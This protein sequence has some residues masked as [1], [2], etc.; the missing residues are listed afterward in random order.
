M[1]IGLTGGIGCGK[2]TALNIFAEMGWHTMSTDAIAH[3][4]ITKDA[5]VGAELMR[6][7]GTKEK[8]M[9]AKEVF[10]NVEKKQDLEEILHPRIRQ[11]WLSKIENNPEDN[12]VIEI[13]LLIEKSL[14][15]YFDLVVCVASS[16]ENQLERL[17]LRGITEDDAKARI[18]NQAPLSLK[19]QNSDR[20]LSNNGTIL[21][22]EE[23]IK[24]L[25]K[26][27]EAQ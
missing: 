13:P 19:I 15:N 6:I 8:Q 10:S 11:H 21:F 9:I 23:Q 27:L 1:K 7:F 5:E 18:A 2:S 4:L 22:L 3:E 20:V 16:L 24:H 25:H 26:Q 14:E 12:W 17:H